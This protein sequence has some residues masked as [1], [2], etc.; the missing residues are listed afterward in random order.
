MKLAMF[1]DV[2][3]NVHKIEVSHKIVRKII[4]RV[5]NLWCEKLCFFVLQLLCGIEWFRSG[6]KVQGD[7]NFAITMTKKV[8]TSIYS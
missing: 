2:Y 7:Y 1:M 5:S 8:F 3:L 6:D 4:N